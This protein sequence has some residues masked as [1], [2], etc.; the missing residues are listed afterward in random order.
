M[1]YEN[2]PALTGQGFQPFAANSSPTF[3]RVAITSLGPGESVDLV[4]PKRYIHIGWWAFYEELTEDFDSMPEGLYLNTLHW[5][6]FDRESWSDTS[7][8]QAGGFTGFFYRLSTG[9]EAEF[10]FYS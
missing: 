6:Q 5:I 2:F 10:D 9:V 1:P 4:A 8:I 7:P 3:I